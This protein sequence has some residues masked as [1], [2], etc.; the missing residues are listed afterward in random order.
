MLELSFDGR[1]GAEAVVRAHVSTSTAQRVVVAAIVPMVVVTLALGVANDHLARPIAATLYWS[2]LIVTSMGVG[3][4]WWI[5]RPASRFGPL[6]IAFGVCAW[7]VSWQASDLP[8]AYDLGVLAEGPTFMLTFYLFLA[9]PMGRIEPPAARWVMV[10]LFVAVFGFFVPWALLTPALAGAG[11]LTA[12]ASACPEN[13]LQVGLAPDLVSKIGKAETYLALGVT[14][15]TIVIYGRRLATA[16]RPQRRA[17]MAVAVTSLLWLPAYFVTNFARLVL[18]ASA[19]TVTTLGWFIVAARVLLPLGFLFAL[20]QADRFAGAALK[21]LFEHIAQRPSPQRWRQ[22]IAGALDDP[23]VRIGYYDPT[24]DVFREP[25]GSE[26]APALDGGGR[27][28]VPIQRDGK[29]VAAMVVDETLTED[30]ELVRA[31]GTATLVAVQHGALEGE[32]RHQIERDIH[33]SAQQRL[34]ALRIN[35]ALAGE[36]LESVKDR[37]VFERLDGEVERTI[38]ELRAVTKGTVPGILPQA[39]LGAALQVAAAEAG[40]PVTMSVQGLTRH[41]A[42]LETAVYFCCMECLQNAAKHA[43]R[44]ASV[45][46]RLSEADGRLRF[47]VSDDGVG[48]DPAAVARGA[49]LTNLAERVGAAAGI[50]HIEARPGHGTRVTGEVPTS[51]A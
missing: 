1:A 30:P 11:A 13:V 36:Q 42:E 25:D 18:E 47:C 5:R 17:L 33:D 51:P 32:V 43:G 28:W 49:G 40:I 29:P 2:Y 10:V 23:E 6:L 9:F 38:E 8:L 12:C 19:E 21:S 35:L 41:S 22:A 26:I 15:A 3:V 20:W 14:L 39:G 45:Q 24:E 16:S 37:E 44:D 48:F 31:A 34:V 50:L 27:A 7:I 46:L 4:Y